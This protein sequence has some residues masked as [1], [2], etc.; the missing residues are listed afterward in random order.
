MSNAVLPDILFVA[1]VV[2]VVVV[3]VIVVVAINDAVDAVVVIAVFDVE[4]TTNVFY[5]VNHF[6]EAKVF[7]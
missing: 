2:V 7:R 1:L 4:I 6:C 3:I 5:G